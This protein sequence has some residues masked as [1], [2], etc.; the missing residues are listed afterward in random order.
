MPWYPF[1][2]KMQQSDIMVMLIHCQ[3]EKN[4]YQNRF[5]MNDKWHT[6]SVRKGM[7]SIKDKIYINPYED[8]ATIKN[9]LPHK[10][11]VLNHFDSEITDSLSTTN[12]GI[13][14]KLREMLNISTQLK[15][16][17]PTDLTSTARLVDICKTYGATAY[18]S[19][20]GAKTYLDESLFKREGIEVIY[21][22]IQTAVPILEVL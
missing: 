15:R 17:Y 12:V 8:W 18:L 5:N 2:E 4:G 14:F 13:I 19:G 10:N 16:D 21:Q 3:F 6:M 7:E 9:K 11:N 20:I 22:T 1:F